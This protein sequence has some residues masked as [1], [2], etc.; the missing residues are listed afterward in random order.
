[1]S[2][3]D[4]RSAVLLLTLWAGV[5]AH[6]FAQS[7]E[8]TRVFAS[9][10]LA[11]E[12]VSS[13][14]VDESGVYVA[15]GTGDGFSEKGKGSAGTFVRKYNSAGELV[16]SRVFVDHSAKFIASGEGKLLVIGNTGSDAHI[17]VFGHG[18]EELSVRKLA[19]NVSA[20]KIAVHSS[21]VYILESGAE[22]NSRHIRGVSFDGQDLSVHDTSVDIKDIAA[23]GTGIFTLNR[24]GTGGRNCSL[25]KADPEGTVVWS[26]EFG[27]EE[28][29][30]CAAIAAHSGSLYVAGT[31]SGAFS[32]EVP[33]GNSDMFVSRFDIDGK[34]L[35]AR[36]FGTGRR[37]RAADITADSTGVYF[38]GYTDGALPGFSKKGSHDVVFRKF[39][40]TGN[41]YGTAQFG[42][43][44][45]A[46]RGAFLGMFGLSVADSSVP[47]SIE[48]GPS[49]VYIGGLVSPLGE[50]II[51][52]MGSS[53]FVTKIN[54]PTAQ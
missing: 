26:I 54:S 24:I 48:V 1:M 50:E 38:A 31:V 53:A 21:G 20:S 34:L 41:E 4:F 11:N 49:G 52:P 23:D 19:A 12:F 16:W 9:P 2:A 46:P 5:A 15:G 3:K 32:G 30:S 43:R 39:D 33:T 44:D 25:T 6:G 14:A 40:L 42:N 27:G 8:W 28:R 10:R 7:V 36:Q 45:D 37:D 18:G 29:A 35:W 13:V 17:R 47:M 22:T 51:S